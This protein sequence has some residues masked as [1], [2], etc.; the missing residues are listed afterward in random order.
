MN[1]A[2]VIEQRFQRAGNIAAGMKRRFAFKRL[3]GLLLELG[4]RLNELKTRRHLCFQR[5]TSQNILTEGVKG[6]RSQFVLCTQQR[7][8]Q[9]SCLA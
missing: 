5:K 7:F 9:R 8:E 3:P 6:G 4:R 2:A 1:A